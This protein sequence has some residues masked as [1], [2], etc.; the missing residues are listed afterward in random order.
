MIGWAIDARKQRYRD[1]TPFTYKPLADQDLVWDEAA[2]AEI[3]DY[4]WL[5][6]S[7]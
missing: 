3:V 2:R 6:L 7:I 5:D 1:E 4:N